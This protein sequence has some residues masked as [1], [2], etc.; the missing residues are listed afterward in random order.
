LLRRLRERFPDRAL[1][2]A[3]SLRHPLER[4]LVRQALQGFQAAFYFLGTASARSLCDGL[5]SPAARK[6]FMELLARAERRFGFA[7]PRELRQWLT[8]R[9]DILVRIGPDVSAEAPV[10]AGCSRQVRINQ[11]TGATRYSF[12]Y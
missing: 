2:L 7:D 6:E 12:E 8:D 5:D 4:L 11:E 9:P 1:V 3:S 10:E